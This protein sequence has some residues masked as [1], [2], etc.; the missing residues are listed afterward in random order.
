MIEMQNIIINNE[1]SIRL[2][3]FFTIFCIM[4]ILESIIT[5]KKLLLSKNKRWLNNISLV[6][7]NTLI[8]R[9]L[10]P[11]ATLGVS[12]YVHNNGI[13]LFNIID[14]LKPIITLISWFSPP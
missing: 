9:I 3:F 2:L 6:F 14:S 7:L 12:I 10:F 4:A 13:G 8:I 5:K 1:V 11:T